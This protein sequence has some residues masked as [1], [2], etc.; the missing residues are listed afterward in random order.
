MMKKSVESIMSEKTLLSELSHPFLVNMRSAFQDM[1]NLY[2]VMDY[3][4]GG[5]LRFHL[6]TKVDFSESECSIVRITQSL[7][8]PVLYY[9]WSSYGTIISFIAI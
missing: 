6:F 9:L 1:E 7:S 3:L 2:L 8:S 5:D 4:S